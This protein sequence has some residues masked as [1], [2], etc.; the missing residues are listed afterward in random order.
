[1][2]VFHFGNVVSLATFSPIVERLEFETL[3]RRS[4]LCVVRTMTS[5]TVSACGMT[6]AVG[7]TAPSACAALRGRL[8]NFQ[9]TRF[10]ARDGEW[11]LGA[12]APLPQSSRG[13][14]RLV[15][16]LVPALRECIDA[17][18]M[19]PTDIP[20]LLCLA[21]QDR[22]GRVPGLE[23]AISKRLF[24][25]IGELHEASRFYADGGVGG[26]VALRDAKAL[27]ED[28]APAVIIA[29][30]DS[31]LSAGTLRAFEAEDR[32]MTATNS[33]GFFPG[34]AGAA[35]L[36]T[37]GDGELRIV[38]MGFGA[39]KGSIHSDEPL[40]GHGI[41]QAMKQA[42]DE[43]GLIYEEI[44]Y[45]LA[46]LSGEQ[47]Y[48]REAALGQLRLWRGKGDPEQIWHPADGMG[49]TG[50]AI[51]PICLGVALTAARKRYAPGPIALLHA[52]HDDGR[53]AA[54]VMRSEGL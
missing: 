19:E 33:N 26:A 9:E 44:S 5:V 7:L 2:S 14:S 49:E 22:P 36:L 46:D 10:V 40:K 53:R 11:I 24:Q 37:P 28:G 48:F 54:I 32:L 38:G 42:L 30:V 47:Y 27:I 50:A 8:S 34:E 41:A 20:I 16:L 25:E 45:R 3:L 1:M 12:E 13:V 18:E 52:A 15:Q 21:E 23:E 51:I 31:Y 6:S 17:A 35:V 29:G 43:A 39:E 4:P